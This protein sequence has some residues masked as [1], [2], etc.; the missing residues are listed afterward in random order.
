MRFLTAVFLFVLLRAHPASASIADSSKSLHPIGSLPKNS[1]LILEPADSSQTYINP[2]YNAAGSNYHTVSSKN[3][4]Q[5]KAIENTVPPS[6][7]SAEIQALVAQKMLMVQ[8]TDLTSSGSTCQ[9]SGTST[10]CTLGA[11]VPI[12][13]SGIFDFIGRMFSW[14]NPFNWFKSEAPETPVTGADGDKKIVDAMNKT[15]AKGNS[16]ASANGKFVQECEVKKPVADLPNDKEFQCG[17]EQAKEA[18]RKNKNQIKKDVFIFNDFAD[19]ERTGKMWFLNSDGTPARVLSRNPIPVSRGEGGFGAGTDSHKT[20]NGAI[21]T[22]PYDPPRAGI[23]RDG[24]ELVGLESGNTDIH[25]RGI[26]LH[27]WDPYD[28]TAGCLGVAGEITSSSRGYKTRVEGPA[29]PYLDE[30]KDGLLK[31]GGV[32][33]YNFTPS[34]S[35]LCR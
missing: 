15:I 8:K 5:V 27:G 4:Y 2:E 23:I 25:S 24:I 19:G 26:L 1:K 35:S 14:L 17:V 18:F 9:S 20:P 30:L 33:I 12:F 3:L 28:L 7:E 10:N 29:P 13:K 11:E 34:K 6:Q 31:D 16:V 32:M 22:K 21:L